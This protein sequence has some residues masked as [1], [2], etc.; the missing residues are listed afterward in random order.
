MKDA[1]SRYVML[2]HEEKVTFSLDECGSFEFD[3]AKIW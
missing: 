1:I 3:F 2:A